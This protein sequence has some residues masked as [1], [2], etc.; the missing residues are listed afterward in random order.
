MSA[1][2]RSQFFLRGSLQSRGLFEGAGECAL[3]WEERD[4]KTVFR[5]Q[6][7]LLVSLG[8]TSTQTPL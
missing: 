8:D 1:N 7:L 6:R 2:F 5:D 3:D 4:Q